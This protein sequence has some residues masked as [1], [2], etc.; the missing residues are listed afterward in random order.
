[1]Y[2]AILPL[3]P[4]G[5]SRINEFV[6]V[7]RTEK[8]WTY[9]SY[10]QPVY[11]HD[12]GDRTG[13]YLTACQMLDAGVCRECEILEVFGVPK[14]TLDNWQDKYRKGGISSF[15]RRPVRKK[16]S[17]VLTPEVLE[18]A[19]CLLDEGLSRSQIA[20]ELCVKPCTLRKAI[21]DHRL[22]ER[23]RRCGTTK[24]ERT[25]R[26]AEA[27][28]GMG[29]ACTRLDERFLAALGGLSGA[30]SLF[31]SSLSVPRGGVLCALPAL[32]E[33]GLLMGVDE[34]LC[35]IRG[36]YTQYHILL[37][38]GLMALCRIKTVE[39]LS[40][41]SS[42]EMGILLGLDRAPEVHCLRRKMDEMAGED[43]A[44]IWAAHLSR[45]WMEL[46][47]DACGYLYVDGHVSVYHGGQTELPRR[48][49]SRQRLCL[50]GISN[51]WVNDMLGCPFFV[52]EKQIDSGLLA[53]LREDIV[54]RL[55]RDV[56]GQ[57][58]ERE[59]ADDPFLCRFVIVFDREGYS[60][61]F[62]RE[63]W[64]E[65]RIACLSYHKHQG[66]DWPVEFFAEH[67]VTLVHGETVDM[68]LAEMGTYVGSGG[69]GLWMREIRKLS[70]TGHQTAIIG[71]VF[72]PTMALLSPRMFARWCQENFFGY[73]MEHFAIDLLMEHG[74]ETFHGTEKVVNPEWRDLEKQRS[75]ITGKLRHRRAKFA[76]LSMNPE[77]EDDVKRHLN[78]EN[79]KAAL[80]ED[81][82][83]YESRLEEVKTHAKE[84]PRHITWSELPVGRK[85]NKLATSR[86]RLAETVKM[87]AYRA[88]TA[89]AGILCGPTT[90][91]SEARAILRSM[92]KNE[93]DILPGEDGKSLRVIIHGA[94]TPAANRV[95]SKLLDHLNQTETEYP[96]TNLRM[97]FEAAAPRPPPE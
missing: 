19:Q 28:A 75:S 38:L 7:C 20:E 97:I 50:R 93:A 64:V 14:R 30:K 17:T 5:A 21:S 86:K 88:E 65:Y 27:A 60:P 32:L 40:W 85:F 87:I 91:N 37:L 67:K 57:P 2:Q 29:T 13:F 83:Q 92:F 36:Y 34:H 10:D 16:K 24:S 96:G 18:Q 79:S 55:L 41:E 90:S 3:I 1:M 62:F 15:F 78:W 33:N 72:K 6:S 45:Y 61:E 49:V 9:F 63:M 46:N 95:I 76:E 35:A 59:L 56:P 53:A 77:E 84:T 71:T 11:R 66:G 81:I 82:R 22:D 70:E 48:Y 94:P 73:M 89:M 43:N 80:L 47:P 69:A 58:S 26:D 25:V 8:S 42:G 4:E 54:P 52:V 39:K 31:Q 74:T 44:E 68:R 23:K 51:Y 12:P